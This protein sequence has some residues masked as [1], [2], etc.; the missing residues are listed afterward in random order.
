MRFKVNENVKFYCRAILGKTATPKLKSW[1]DIVKKPA[2]VQQGKAV[3]KSPKKPLAVNLVKPSPPRQ[4][5]KVLLRGQPFRHVDL[6]MYFDALTADFS[7][8]CG[9]WKHF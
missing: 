9:I 3:K 6:S 2:V 5:P 4:T 1:A 8:N 7:L